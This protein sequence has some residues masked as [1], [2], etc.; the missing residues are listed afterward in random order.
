MSVP[1]AIV[2]TLLRRNELGAVAEFMPEYLHLS[3]GKG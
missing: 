2:V 1:T 3:D